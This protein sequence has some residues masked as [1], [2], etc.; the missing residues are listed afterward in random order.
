MQC[1]GQKSLEFEVCNSI[2]VKSLSGYFKCICR[3]NF[4]KNEKIYNAANS[5]VLKMVQE[6]DSE[7][8]EPEPGRKE[9][10]TCHLCHN[11]CLCN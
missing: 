4:K 7:P 8:K 10:I 6:I 3:V 1:F 9:Q 2:S 5:E 11:V